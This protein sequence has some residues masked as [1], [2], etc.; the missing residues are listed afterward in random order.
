MNWELARKASAQFQDHRR[1]G[2]AHPWPNVISRRGFARTA[3]G[4]AAAGAAFSAGLWIP[5][6]AEAKEKDEEEKE[7]SQPVP[8][9]GGSPKLGGSFHVF[10]PSPDGSF[11]P[12]D[13]EPAT[14]TDFNGFVGL[15]YISGTVQRTNK[16]TREVRTLPMISS[17]MRFMTGVF[18]GIDGRIHQGAFAL[19]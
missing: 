11:D 6:L 17:D 3:V 2:H 13:A 19:V 18:R 7:S 14:I 1:A 9:R 5:G 12:I 15:A 8:I 4:A 10:G 16:R